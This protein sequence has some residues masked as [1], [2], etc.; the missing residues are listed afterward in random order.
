MVNQAATSILSAD[1]EGIS[2]AAARLR[3]GGLVAFP[4]ET[5]YGL[6]A[7]ATN[8]EAVARIY[9]AKGR[10]STNPLI[11]HVGNLEQAARYAEISTVAARVLGHF[12]PGP[13]TLVLP[14]KPGCTLAKAV[15]AGGDTVAL[16]A[17]VH[18]LAQTLLAEAG[19]PIA[20]PS[21]NPSGRIS[22]TTAQ[23]VLAGLP[24]AGILI[25]DGGACVNGLE[26]TIIKLTED[27][28]TLL[29]PGGITLAELSAVIPNIR[30]AAAA[31]RADAPLPAP[32]ML[33]SHYAPRLPVRLNATEVKPDEALLAF[34]PALQGAARV[35]QLSEGGDLAEAAHRLFSALHLLD[36]GSGYA[37]IAVMP[38]PQEGIGL[39]INDRLKRAAAPR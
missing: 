11:V 26:S 5:V 31:M 15:S 4:T 30:H 38:I 28:A 8:P 23:H 37:S 39:A 18:P 3:E 21:A 36:G 6:G 16:R 1:R 14:R 12:W 13:L 29:R 9:A 19:C 7:D 20:A 10:P 24:E 17:P 32:G 35:V 34:G 27:G 33:E 2:R 22:P 25:L